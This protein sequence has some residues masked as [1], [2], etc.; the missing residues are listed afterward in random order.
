MAVPE[1]LGDPK[2][3][4]DLADWLERRKAKLIKD[5]LPADTPLSP[6]EYLMVQRLGNARHAYSIT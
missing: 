2:S 1:Q 4:R 3:K 5:G 6:R